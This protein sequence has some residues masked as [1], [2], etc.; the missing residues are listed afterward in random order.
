MA[1]LGNRSV[2]GKI[3]LK[4][5]WSD[6]WFHIECCAQCSTRT[7]TTN[8]SSQTPISYPHPS[9]IYRRFLG[10]HLWCRAYE[11]VEMSC[12]VLSPEASASLS[13]GFRSDLPL[14]IAGL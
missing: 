10:G 14:R 13:L 1:A 3:L 11:I 5:S 4:L 8:H 12:A 2:T 6:V 9:P 7:G